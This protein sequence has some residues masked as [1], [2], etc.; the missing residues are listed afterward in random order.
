MKKQK[1]KSK[2]KTKS[3][4]KEGG[5]RHSWVD[6]LD[7]MPVETGDAQDDEDGGF[8]IISW[9]VL[10]DSYCSPRSHRC[11]PQK[12]QN[13][14]FNRNQR[15]HHVQKTLCQL[16][17]SLDRPIFALQEVDAPLGVLTKFEELGY[18]GIETPTS[19][20]GK[21][22]RVD[23]CGLYFDREEW[24]CLKSEAVPLDDL[25][26]L[27]SKSTTEVTVG[28]RNNLQGLQASFLR[29]NMALL[30]K[31]RNVKVNKTVVIAVLHLYW[32][33]N[34]EYVKLCQTH[35]I[36]RNAKD[37]CDGDS[38]IPLVVCGD[39][40]SQ[41]ESYVYKYLSSGTI[42][43]K[44]VTPWY[45]S[46]GF[47]DQMKEETPPQTDEE[48]LQ[49]AL[50][51]KLKIQD[52]SS[53]DGSDDGDDLKGPVKPIRYLLDF[54]LNRFCRWLRI[55]GIDAVLETEEEEKLRT[56]DGNLV[57][58]D[59]CR[60]EKRTLVSTST[61]L[62]LRKDCPPGAYLLD[63]KSLANLEL[64]LIHLLLS[65]GVKLQPRTFLTRCVVC[66]GMICKVTDENQIKQIFEAHSAPDQLHK[67]IFEVFQCKG[68]QQGYWWCEKP[69]SSA[70]RVKSQAASLLEACIRGGVPLDKDMAMFDFVDVEEVKAQASSNAEDGGDGEGLK[71]CAESNLF[72]ERLD[73]IEWLQDEG[74]AN[75]F[76]PMK[77]VYSEYM[78]DQ[79][80][81]DERLKPA[82]EEKIQEIPLIPFTNVTHDF[83]GHLDH[84]FVTQQQASPMSSSSSNRTCIL[85]V[86]QRLY[87]PT[88]YSELNPEGERNGHLLPST[89][90]PS[91][92]LA[93]GAKL[94]WGRIDDEDDDKEAVLETNTA[95]T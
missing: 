31:L 54:T 66:N 38:S 60:T 22:G 61:K 28:T 16:V 75:P 8:S 59:R 70:S 35:H 74:L 94:T 5:S 81:K 21:N 43:A 87:V 73:V 41:P 42:N 93:V 89:A 44:L 13:H 34:Y 9:N 82:N 71:G 39:L 49:W 53:P 68:C 80:G 57:I 55:L 85:E 25:A 27:R 76:G 45:S 1:P 33:P 23:A 67:E 72:L 64:S 12:S 56:K 86:S 52:D 18:D 20:G 40:N 63:T 58:F 46:I 79:E 19:P 50:S 10:A 92:H 62:L 90:W 69:T 4:S 6:D 83:V 15:H 95:G 29:K 88:T 48:L 7:W 78:G 37:F 91:D 26:T 11:L 3:R 84:I 30:V 32:N 51:R 17:S 47:V 14:I 24:V 36:M 77:S 2:R 65:H